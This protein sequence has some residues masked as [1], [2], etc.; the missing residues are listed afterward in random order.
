[1]SLFREFLIDRDDTTSALRDLAG[2]FKQLS[3]AVYTRTDNETYFHRVKEHFGQLFADSIKQLQDA[4][5]G[6]STLCS[7]NSEV[8][9]LL[10]KIGDKVYT[11]S[12]SESSL[13][14]VDS[15][16]GQSLKRLESDCDEMKTS[17]LT[18]TKEVSA[19]VNNMSSWYKVIDRLFD[20]DT[21]IRDKEQKMK[22]MKTKGKLKLLG[23]IVGSVVGSNGILLIVMG[24]II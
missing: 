19:A 10:E 2:A 20:R 18:L 22:K 13:K 21:D 5:T 24:K 12:D 7:A 17:F 16:Y 9:E 4:I 1:V 23:V 15:Q 11:K 14:L 8:H 3:E 6:I